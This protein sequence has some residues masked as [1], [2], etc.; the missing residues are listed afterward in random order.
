MPILNPCCKKQINKNLLHR[1]GHH[2]IP[3][4]TS[5][6]HRYVSV[7]P[8]TPASVFGRLGGVTKDCTMVV[9][10]GECLFISTRK[11]VFC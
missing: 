9:V 10:L 1:C 2:K 3:A 5:T 11:F 4:H 6:H 7:L 8:N